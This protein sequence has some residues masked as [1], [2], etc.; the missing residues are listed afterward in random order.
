MKDIQNKT[1]RPIRVPLPK[2]GSLHLGPRHKGQVAPSALRHPPF[3][4]LVED[5]SIEVLGEGETEHAHA[6]AKMK[7]SANSLGH[8]SSLSSGRGAGDR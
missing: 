1:T 3:M 4:R 7:G 8:G 6:F 2:G 5:G